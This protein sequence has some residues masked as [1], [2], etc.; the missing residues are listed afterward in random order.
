MTSPTPCSQNGIATVTLFDFTIGA[1][2][3]AG[4]IL[5]IVSLKD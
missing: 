1:L 3:A 2:M 4:F 5:I